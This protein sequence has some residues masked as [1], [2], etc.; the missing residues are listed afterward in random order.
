MKSSLKQ[1]FV[2]RICWWE[3]IAVV[4][5]HDARRH[6][7][8][9][10]DSITLTDHLQTITTFHSSV[11]ESKSVGNAALFLFDRPLQSIDPFI[12]P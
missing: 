12:Y 3:E 5:S 11:I 10:T 9:K 7:V 1:I 4:L 2:D 8:G 6:S